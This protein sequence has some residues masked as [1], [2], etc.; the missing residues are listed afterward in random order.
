MGSVELLREARAAHLTVT[1]AG[2]GL[3]VEGPRSA[4]EIVERIKAH[5]AEV[6]Q[7][8]ASEGICSQCGTRPGDAGTDA[9]GDRWCRVCNDSP[10]GTGLDD[11][12]TMRDALRRECFELGET[13]GWPALPYKPGYSI[14]QGAAHWRV[15]MKRASVPDMVMVVEAIPNVLSQFR[16]GE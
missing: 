5:K 14:A 13:A 6:M 12:A 11:A 3:H 2:D 9:N 8:L 10:T 7:A 1:L 16:V 15:W 4:G